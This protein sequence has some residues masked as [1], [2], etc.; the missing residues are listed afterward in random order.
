MS[1]GFPCPAF[2]AQRQKNG[3]TPGTGAPENHP[4]FPM[5][6]EEFA[7]YL[8][9]RQPSMFWMEEVVGFTKRVEAL[10]MSPLAHV[11]SKCRERGYAVEAFQLCH[12]VFINVRR[13]RVYFLGAHQRAGGAA[14]IAHC[15][16]AVQQAVQLLEERAY[17]RPRVFDIVDLLSPAEVR[18][19]ETNDCC[20]VCR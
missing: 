3:S 18:R 11:A 17:S 5:A 6:V 4:T 14:A 2:S 13:P 16:R 12:S 8:S 9:E 1:G 15:S 10:G 20:F 19:R 7:N